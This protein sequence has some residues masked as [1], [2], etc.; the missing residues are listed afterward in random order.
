MKN[1]SEI[2][3]TRIAMPV[4]EVLQ[5]GKTK[6]RLIASKYSRALRNK[7]EMKI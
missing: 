3:T 6:P 2:V 7:E 4:N 1:E 5:A